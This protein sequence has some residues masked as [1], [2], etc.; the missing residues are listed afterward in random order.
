MKRQGPVEKRSEAQLSERARH[1]GVVPLTEA[2]RV[3]VDFDRHV[4]HDGGDHPR[5]ERRPFVRG[6]VLSHL[7]LDPSGLGRCQH[8]F[9]RAVLLKQLGR[10]LLPHS[11]YAGD[12]VTRVALEPKVVRDLGGRDAVALQ[13]LIG[14]HD[15]DIGDSLLGGD[16][17]NAIVHQL[18]RIAVAGHEQYPHALGGSSHRE[19]S[20]HVVAFPALQLDDGDRHGLE[21]PLDHGELGSQRLGGGWAVHL[22]ALKGLDAERGFAPIEGHDHPVRVQIGDQLHEHRHETVGGIRWPPVRS[23]HAL[24]Q[25]ME[26]AMQ[27]R[28]AVDDR[29]RA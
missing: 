9:E 29:D 22:V 25:R 17:L 15:R 24:R 11:R 8:G 26:S 12:V 16:D 14:S 3:E 7:A 10:G 13:D 23:R 6:E 28:V 1:D 2:H 21:E 19:R 4:A 27:K 18:E 20:Q 5:R